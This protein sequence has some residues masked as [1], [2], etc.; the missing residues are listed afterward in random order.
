M[1]NRER[2]NIGKRYQ[3]S[4]LGKPAFAGWTVTSDVRLPV[5][6]ANGTYHE[7]VSFD[8]GNATILGRH[9]GAEQRLELYGDGEALARLGEVTVT[10][11]DGRT[12][13]LMTD[14]NA[15]LT[16]LAA[17]SD[18]ERDRFGRVYG[19]EQVVVPNARHA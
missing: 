8:L 3:M 19:S 12:Y 11:V 7:D 1:G 10:G 2:G 13:Q 6:E 18:S 15:V 4:Q 9:W 17:L 14:P 16:Y 5:L